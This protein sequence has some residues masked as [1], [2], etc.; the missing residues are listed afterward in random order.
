MWPKI[1]SKIFF[2]Q[3]CITHES[4]TLM[5]QKLETQGQWE[6]KATCLDTCQILQSPI[7]CDITYHNKLLLRTGHNYKSSHQPAL[8]FWEGKQTWS[9]A[10]SLLYQP[11]KQDHQLSAPKITSLRLVGTTTV[12]VLQHSLMGRSGWQLTISKSY[13]F[14][15]WISHKRQHYLMSEKLSVFYISL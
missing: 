6:R 10:L 11:D 3:I 1:E 13:S 7:S 2:C 12:M 5:L 15:M 8:G 9:Q 14:T 4:T